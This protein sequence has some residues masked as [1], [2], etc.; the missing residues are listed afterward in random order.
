MAD[1]S[2]IA[3]AIQKVAASTP[4]I[5]TGTVSDGSDSGQM[6]I[7][8]D[9]DPSRKPVSA[10]SLV[11]TGAVTGARVLAIRY[12]PRGLVVLG[13]LNLPTPTIVQR[14]FV[15]GT[16]TK[17]E[18]LRGVWVE[19]QAAGGG[20]GGCATTPIN[21]TSGSGGG[22]GGGYAKFWVPELDLPASV[23]VVVGIGG[24][25]GA[26][27]A[28]A[29][30]SGGLSSFSTF[31]SIPG[32]AGGAGGGTAAFSGPTST[33]NGGTGNQNFTGT[34]SFPIVIQGSDGGEGF[35]IGG[36]PAVIP[37]YGGGSAM[38]G[39]ARVGAVTNP[40]GVTHQI[41]ANAGW[42][43]GGG[44]SGPA[45]M[46]TDGVGQ[47]AGAGGSDGVVYVTEIYY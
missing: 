31:G 23:P 44:A 5:V 6:Q 27:G 29:G 12:P 7:I 32:G 47:R 39:M 21:Q 36:V 30:T 4:G 38:A 22:Q 14:Y 40:S 15:N 16:W 35:R 43:A 46:G 45:N 11:G 10:L 19:L 13:F 37:G 8:L 2:Q 26:A 42:F 9:S 25:G 41:A 1:L 24:N 17:P 3:K 34:A 28:N 20:S 33:Q 18:G